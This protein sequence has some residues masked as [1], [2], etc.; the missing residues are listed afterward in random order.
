[1]QPI[2]I[3]PLNG[4]EN[5]GR[6]QENI[7]QLLG[8]KPC[9]QIYGSELHPEI[10]RWADIVKELAIDFTLIIKNLVDKYLKAVN[11]PMLCAP[12]FNNEVK[13]AMGAPAIKRH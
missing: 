7:S 3:V 1:M 6:N 11:F 10:V 4:D 8:D 12:S 13:S 2:Q 9:K 5:K